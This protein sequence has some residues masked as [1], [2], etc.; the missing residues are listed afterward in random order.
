MLTAAESTDKATTARYPNFRKNVSLST[1]HLEIGSHVKHLSGLLND[2]KK[3]MYTVPLMTVP[4]SDGL[5]LLDLP[6]GRLPDWSDLPILDLMGTVTSEIDIVRTGSERRIEI[7]DCNW[8][9]THSAAHDA[10]ELL[11]VP[12]TS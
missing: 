12:E 6:Q 8:D 2:Q 1:N 9:T 7:S 4:P 3:A 11:C 5:G 10:R